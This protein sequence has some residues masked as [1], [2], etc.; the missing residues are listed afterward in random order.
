MMRACVCVCGG[1]VCV[2]ARGPNSVKVRMYVNVILC[3]KASQ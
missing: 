2:C 1:C 3:V